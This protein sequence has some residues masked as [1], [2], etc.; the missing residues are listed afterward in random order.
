MP[1]TVIGGI[2]AILLSYGTWGMPMVP[3]DVAIEH[4]ARVG[5]DAMS[6][7]IKPGWTTDVA[8]LDAAEKSR[9]RALMDRHGIALAG[10]SGQTSLLEDDPE[11]LA[12]HL[13]L[14]HRFI[15]ATAD[16]QRTGEQLALAMSAGGRPGE[17]DAKRTQAV[18]RFGELARHAE[19]RGVIVMAEPNVGSALIDPA[20][21]VW[22]LD[23]VKS[24]ALKLDLDISHF[25][26]QGMDPV[27][28]IEQLAPHAQHVEVKDERGIAPNH[29][30]L[31]P[32]EGPCD[33][34]TILRT[35]DR[36]GYD[37]YVEVE[38]SFMVQRRPNYDPLA[39]AEQSYRVLAPAFEAAGL[40]RPRS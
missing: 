10:I 11:T 19:R 40:K 30:F 9:I 2:M 17:W 4:C 32:G 1:G 22:L 14:C 18:E 35:L 31:I 3:I 26:A 6:I 39:A 36:V 33:Y 12:H 20:E 8:T 25:N 34:V 37:H 21:A 24:P 28:V 27:A 29:E 15:D 7:T 16:F 5:Y 38:I 23:Q 13:D